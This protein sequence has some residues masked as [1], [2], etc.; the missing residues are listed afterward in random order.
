MGIKIKFGTK[1]RPDGNGGCGGDKG[2]CIVIETSL[3]DGG[4]LGIN[5]GV[6]D[7]EIVNQSG[8]TFLRWDME[9]DNS[10]NQPGAA[11]N[12]RG[13]TELSPEVSAALGQESVTIQPGTYP[14][15]YST[16][17]FGVALLPVTTVAG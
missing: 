1:S 16:N 14:M 11:F 12:V 15:D 2:I 13:L 4:V 5:E 17:P 8:H 7:G 3:F 10:D 9:A 6:A